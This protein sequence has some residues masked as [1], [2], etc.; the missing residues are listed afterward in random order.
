MSTRFNNLCKS[1]DRK[2]KEENIKLIKESNIEDALKGQVGNTGGELIGKGVQ[3]VISGAAFYM[4]RSRLDTFIKKTTP[5]VQG[6]LQRVD[7]ISRLPTWDTDSRV[8]FQ[9]E[10]EEVKEKVQKWVEWL[11]QCPNV[12]S[13]KAYRIKL[14]IIQTDLTTAENRAVYRTRSM[15]RTPPP[16]AP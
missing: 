2:Y 3:K 7:Q 8:K 11:K 9:T 6:I 5:I 13:V 16:P 12:K 14:N 4:F 15:P 10:I 1:V